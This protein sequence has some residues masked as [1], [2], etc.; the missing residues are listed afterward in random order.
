[1]PFAYFAHLSR[2]DQVTYER[3]DATSTLR[4]PGVEELWPAVEDLRAAL[5]GEDGED[6][7]RSAFAV[8]VGICRAL[9]ARPPRLEVHA[10][11]P[12]GNTHELHGLYVPEPEGGR[13]ATIR[14]WMRTARKGRAVA[15]RTFL[16]TLLHELV[17]HFDYELLALDNSFHTEGF[18]RR[19]SS[20]FWQLVPGSP[21]ARSRP[22]DR[23]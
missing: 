21:P 3:S 18:F 20:L 14:V 17:H 4:V 9:G 11:R 16:R 8:C 6:V 2:R 22:S 5:V 7:A 15:F 19:E 1:M 10:V 23:A 12:R 13:P